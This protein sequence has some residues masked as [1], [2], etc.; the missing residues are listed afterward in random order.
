MN[1]ETAALDALA[2]LHRRHA[3]VLRA[4]DFAY[5]T[6]DAQHVTAVQVRQV[7]AV[8]AEAVREATK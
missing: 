8:I 4:L 6:L 2:D 5:K 1:T 3:V 7:R